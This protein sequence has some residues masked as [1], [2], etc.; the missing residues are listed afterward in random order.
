[1]IR[2][3]QS[4]GLL[5]GRKDLIEAA[6]LNSSPYSDSIGRGMKVNKEELVGMMVAV[7]L[8]TKRDHDAEWKDWEKRVRTIADS[9]GNIKGIKPETLIPEI[10]NHVP[11]LK[12]TWDPNV[13]KIT[14]AEVVKQL[15]DGEPSIEVTPGHT[16]A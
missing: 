6:R 7:E 8:F 9:V 15:R 13:V 12:L 3:P 10:S 14:P 16:D 5:L 11:H 1:G 2:G 4:C